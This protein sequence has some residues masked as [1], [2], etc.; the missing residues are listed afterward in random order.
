MVFRQ[1]IGILGLICS[2][3]ACLRFLVTVRRASKRGDKPYA[4]SLLIIVFGSVLWVVGFLL[5]L[6]APCM[7]STLSNMATLLILNGG[8][9]YLTGVKSL[10]KSGRMP[11]ADPDRIL[12]HSR[13]K[14]ERNP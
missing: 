2:L 10:V 4:R 7:K 14:N 6:L 9:V 3:V 11:S 1:S 13:R 5:L 8:F 12:I